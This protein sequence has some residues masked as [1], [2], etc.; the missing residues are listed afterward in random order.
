[1]E[2]R[3]EIYPYVGD[4]AVLTWPSDISF[5]DNNCLKAF[6]EF[7]SE[8]ANKRAYYQGHY[9]VVPVFKGGLNTGRVMVAEVGVV[10]RDIAYHSDVLNTELPESRRYAMKRMPGFWFQ[11]R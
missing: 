6:F 2:S 9:G 7:E 8:L 1:M 11:I 10:K 5:E 3:A 4:E